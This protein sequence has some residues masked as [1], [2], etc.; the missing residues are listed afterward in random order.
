MLDTLIQDLEKEMTEAELTEKDAQEDYET[1]MKDSK[2]KRAQD[3]KSLLD[4][5]GALADLEASLGDH[6][7]N[8][9]STTKELS[10]TND[11]ISNL[12]L[13]C[14]FLLKYYDMRK[15]ARTNEID[16]MEKA[17][18]VLNGADFSLIQTSAHAR[19]FLRH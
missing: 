14:D 1:M 3:S 8:L 12:H 10:A 2:E 15:E 6:K 19:K 5:E 17:T 11:Y 13:E 4:K 18:A 9:E 7:G 16:A